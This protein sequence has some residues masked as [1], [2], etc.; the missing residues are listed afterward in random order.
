FVFENYPGAPF[1]AWNRQLQI[2]NPR[3]IDTNHY[4]LS[5]SVAPAATTTLG[6]TY[7][8]AVFDAGFADRLLRH[9]QVV[10]ER[11]IAG[12]TNLERL[13]RTPAA[14]RRQ[15]IAEWNGR[16]V[17]LPS[18]SL[19]QSIET[20]AARRPDAVAVEWECGSVTYGDLNRRANQ[21]A[22][23]LRR[24]GVRPE[25]RVGISMDRSPSFIVA[26]LA[27][28]KAGGAFVPLD[29]AYPVERL[30]YMA[31][32]AGVRLTLTSGSAPRWAAGVDA[33]MLNLLDAASGIAAERFD[34]LPTTAH[35]DSLAYVMFTSGS[36]GRPKGVM[37]TH[38]N[39]GEFAAWASADFGQPARV[40]AT[41]AFNFDASLL[42]LT[43]PLG[44]GG[45]VVLKPH[46]LALADGPI[47]AD[48]ILTVPSTMAAL[49]E[50]GVRLDRITVLLGAEPLTRELLDATFDAGAARVMNL[51][52]PTEATVA[53]TGAAMA[54]GEPRVPAIGRPLWNRRVYVLDEGGEPVPVGV[55]GELYLG[56]AGV[57]R[58]YESQPALTAGRFVPDPFGFAGDRLYRTGDRVRWR[59]GGLVVYDGRTDEQVKIRGYRVELGEVAATLRRHPSVRDAVAIVQ[60]EDAAARLIAFV[61]RRQ[62]AEPAADELRAFLGDH[63][64]E[65]MVPAAL[66]VL[67]AL[68]LTPHGKLDRARLPN[69]IGGPTVPPAASIQPGGADDMDAR[70]QA[71]WEEVLQTR[72]VGPDDN[73]FELGG[74]SLLAVTLAVRVQKVFGVPIPVAEVI[75]SPTLRAMAAVLRGGEQRA[76]ASPAIVIQPEGSHPPFFC[77]HPGAGDVLV[78]SRLARHLG[79]AQPFIGIQ[80]PGMPGASIERRAATYL[81]EIVRH[82][83]SGP[84]YLG[85]WSFGGI[86]AFEMAHQLRRR[87]ETTAFLG[88]IDAGAPG[89]GT[90]HVEEM[91]AAMMMAVIGREVAAIFGQEC[92]IAPEDLE[93]LA[94]GERARVVLDRLKSLGVF[95]PETD[96]SVIQHL[97]HLF[98]TRIA[99]ARQ[100]AAPVYEGRVTLFRSTGLPPGVTVAASNDPSLGWSALCAELEIHD[101]PGDHAT[102]MVEPHVLTLAEYL[103]LAL[104]SAR[105]DVTVSTPASPE[106]STITT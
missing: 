40:A 1:P 87:G 53:A 32:T 15:V 27:I 34:D 58:G 75:R 97:A 70:L 7:D 92:T 22:R 39:L 3:G 99:S 48:L 90:R 98:Q 56:G 82:Q 50:R 16:P 101:M 69:P 96:P 61:V 62:G 10:L 19:V 4:P 81:D 9:A 37:I 47:D 72:P 45:T 85:G 24:H 93:P 95:P 26:M 8:T 76:A 65:V 54:R 77:V 105:Q 55:Q 49:L 5:I 80:D 21:L 63:L 67:D 23:H 46:P 78:Y 18:R 71:I 91:S 64:P 29:P 35:G 20:Q 83:P 2:E 79:R 41:I 12:E 17:D 86:V 88:L 84:Y 73:F 28:L 104:A 94:V 38:G 13:C 42:E 11:L 52:G 14:D 74:H 59:E 106:H 31:A 89:A 44:A 102:M 68:P 30:R 60:G 6:C 57:A 36:S 51:Y 103:R 25:V 100:Y 33:Q 43:A 66:V